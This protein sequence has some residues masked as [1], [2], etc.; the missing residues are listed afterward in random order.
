MPEQPSGAL[1]GPTQA[2]TPNS[3]LVFF[4]FLIPPST[5]NPEVMSKYPQS[6]RDTQASP[7][8][9]TLP[10]IAAIPHLMAGGSSSQP[11]P[12]R[13]PVSRSQLQLQ[14]AGRLRYFMEQGNT[15]E[16]TFFESAEAMSWQCYQEGVKLCEKK[17]SKILEQRVEINRLMVGSSPLLVFLLFLTRI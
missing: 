5:G 9:Q 2:R 14:Q 13:G 4:E 15:L 11:N 12:M 10:E 6:P 7:P 8:D 17:D 1:Y 3:E 16:A